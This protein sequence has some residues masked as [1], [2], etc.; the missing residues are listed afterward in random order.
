MA[1]LLLKGEYTKARHG[2]S[3]EYIKGSIAVTYPFMQEVRW[4]NEVIALNASYEFA[5]NSYLRLTYQF[6]NATGED[7]KL[8]TPDFYQGK[9]RTFSFGFNLGF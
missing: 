9:N 7:V 8:F 3:Y 6:N 2:R 4:T 5:F 1:R